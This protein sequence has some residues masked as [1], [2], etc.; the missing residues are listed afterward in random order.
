MACALPVA[1]GRFRSDSC[2]F[3]LLSS[4][5]LHRTCTLDWK[6]ILKMSVFQLFVLML[7]CFSCYLVINGLV[8]FS[9]SHTKT[10]QKHVDGGPLSTCHLLKPPTGLC[11]NWKLLLRVSLLLSGD[12]GSKPW[13]TPIRRE[14]SFH[15]KRINR[16][17]CIWPGTYTL[18]APCN[19]TDL[20]AIY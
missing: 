20:I 14:S 2:G 11:P 6:Y 3:I 7:A 13:Q 19:M 1:H 12:V 8:Y 9:Y 10:N 16:W 17:T 18:P 15:I 5:N 4:I